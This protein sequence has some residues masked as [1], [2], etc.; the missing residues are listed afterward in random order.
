MRLTAACIA[1]L[2]QATTFPHYAQTVVDF[3]SI[4]SR[5]IAS[6]A[7]TVFFALRGLRLDAHDYIPQVLE[8]GVKVLVIHKEKYSESWAMR[9]Q[10]LCIIQVNDTLEALQKVAAYIR[11]A[12]Q[13]LEVIGITGSN[14]KTIVK[15]WLSHLT[16]SSHY[17]IKSPKSFNSQVGVPL[18]VWSLSESHSL[19]I[20][21]AGISKT[22]EMARLQEIIDPTLGIITN[23][24]TAHEDGFESKTQ[25]LEEKLLLFKHARV[26]IYCKDHTEVHQAIVS[27]G[28]P[29]LSWS[30]RYDSGCDFIVDYNQNQ[31]SIHFNNQT[32]QCTLQYPP[33]DE[34]SKENLAHA[35]CMCV[36]LGIPD[37]RMQQQL[38]SLKTIPMRLQW[39]Q[40]IH[41]SYIVDDSYNNDLA[42]LQVA[43]DFMNRQNKSLSRT[44]ILSDPEQE[45]KGIDLWQRQ[46]QDWIGAYGLKKLILIGTQLAQSMK[47][48]D[49]VETFASVNYFLDKY[50]FGQLSHQVILIKGSRSSGFE[51]IV[52]RL[53]LRQ[54]STCLHIHLPTLLQNFNYIKSLLLPDTKIMVM[55]KSFAY[56]AG[57]MEVAQLLQ[58]AGCHYLGVAYVDEG[59][60][61]RNQG[62]QLPIMVLNAEEI[63]LEQ[64][65]LHDLEPVVYSPAMLSNIAILADTLNKQAS[66]HLEI[67]TGMNRLGLTSD[68]LEEIKAQLQIYRNNI[69]IKSVFSHLVGS[70]NPQLDEFTWQ[71]CQTLHTCHE[72]LS[73]TLGYVPMKHILNSA[74]ILRHTEFQMDMVRLGIGFYGVDPR[75][76]TPLKGLKSPFRLTSVISQIK[77]LSK[78]ETVGYNRKGVLQRDST[79]GIVAIGYG[80]GFSR[81]H[82]NGVGSIAIHGKI[83]PIIGNVCMDMCMVDLTDIPE[84]KEGQEVEIFGDTI[85]LIAMAE[86]IGTIPYE[87]LT[88][89]SP[90]IKRIFYED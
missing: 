62:I 76:D 80:D 49:T 58:Y 19:A 89:I 20:F 51:K 23:I 84:A 40:G 70:E 81:L 72:D 57:S 30:Y 63:T 65:L 47:G 22:G 12:H 2:C 59:I 75:A 44:L 7:Q 85:S 86:R 17:V 27:R 13:G 16:Q 78:D 79:I 10:D 1:E 33:H 31:L 36:Y 11:H 73:K 18:S 67:E 52:D 43:L 66:V 29:G 39:K 4:D 90:R 37:E 9:R 55:V 61:L 35:L 69:L 46:L 50:D 8:S 88:S 21:E 25:K 68:H 42:G 14:G 26:L 60:A 24:G 74:G 34:A 71:Q 15:E 41:G 32:H 3:V 5:K 82:S 83:A 64:C 53:S 48:L 54:H 87:I 45:T 28:L 6:P 56:G 77:H 38:L